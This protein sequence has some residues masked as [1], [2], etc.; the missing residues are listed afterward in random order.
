MGICVYLNTI[1][2]ILA[3]QDICHNISCD[4]VITNTA[5]WHTNVGNEKFKL[6][7]LNNL[8][9]VHILYTL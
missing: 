5:K 8:K 2:G 7:F 1:L 9:Y 4:N 3:C 6:P